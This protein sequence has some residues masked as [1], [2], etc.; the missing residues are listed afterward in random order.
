[1]VAAITAVTKRVVRAKALATMCPVI[2]PIRMAMA[3]TAAGKRPIMASIP[4]S[5]LSDFIGGLINEGA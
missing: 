2:K 4:P 3:I 1:M 5:I